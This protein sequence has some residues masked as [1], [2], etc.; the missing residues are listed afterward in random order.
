MKKL[1]ILMLLISG[2]LKAETTWIPIGNGANFIIIPFIPDFTFPAPNNAKVVGGLLAWD[3]VKHASKYLIQGKTPDG[4]WKDIFVTTYTFANL[5]NSFFGFEEVRVKACTYY[6]CVDTGYLSNISISNLIEFPKRKFVY[7]ALGR[8]IKVY[9]TA[10]TDT[11]YEYDPAG[12]RKEMKE[13]KN[14]K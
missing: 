13:S 14:E 12:N 5:D 9:D 10:G 7:D 4:E 6:S 3:N 11:D 1:I 8:L 2:T